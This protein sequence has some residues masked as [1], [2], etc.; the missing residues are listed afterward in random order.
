MKKSLM[1]TVAAVAL[2][3]G[4][5]LVSAEGAKE[6]SD[7]KAGGAVQSEPAMKQGADGKANADTKPKASTTGQASEPKAAPAAKST[8]DDKAAPAAKSASDKPAADKAAADTTATI[9]RA[10][11]SAA[12]RLYWARWH[13]R[14]KSARGSSPTAGAGRSKSCWRIRAAR[15]GS[16]RTTAPRPFLR[17][18]CGRTICSRERC[19]SSARKPG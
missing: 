7:A 15:S 3:A 16:A 18:W 10:A 14:T 12:L 13:A 6:Q 2:F 1:A 4:P 9:R 17:A 11:R 8:A 5:G 19:G